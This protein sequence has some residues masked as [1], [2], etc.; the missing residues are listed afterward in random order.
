MQKTVMSPLPGLPHLPD[1]GGEEGAVLRREA[2]GL[3][4]WVSMGLAE[5]KAPMEGEELTQ[6]IQS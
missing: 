4:G 5:R 6:P 2:P 3:C 1:P